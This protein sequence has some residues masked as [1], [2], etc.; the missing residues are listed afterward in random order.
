MYDRNNI[1]LENQKKRKKNKK[2]AKGYIILSLPHFLL[3]ASRMPNALN[4]LFISPVISQSFAGSSSSP[5][6]FTLNVSGARIPS[7]ILMSFVSNFTLLLISSKSCG[8]DSFLYLVT[9]KFICTVWN[10]LLNF[11]FLNLYA[12]CSSPLALFQISTCV[13]HRHLTL[14]KIKLIMAC[15]LPHFN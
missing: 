3:L 1:I 11:R 2:T 7:F 10:S 6:S 14:S 5:Q 9:L 8:F 4:F 13:S 12:Y 15:S